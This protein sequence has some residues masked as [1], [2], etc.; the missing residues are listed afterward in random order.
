MTTLIVPVEIHADDDYCGDT[1]PYLV[2][3]KR[4]WSCALFRT[5]L[6]W[7]RASGVD[8]VSRST[9]CLRE[10]VPPFPDIK[11]NIPKEDS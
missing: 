7:A 11:V 9:G 10:A 2:E 3:E 6:D 5:K 8:I 4:D 1:C